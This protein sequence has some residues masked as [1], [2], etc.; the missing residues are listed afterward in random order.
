MRIGVFILHYEKQDVTDRC[1]DAVLADAAGVPN[2]HVFVIDNGSPT[3][4]VRPNFTFASDVPL[5]L[6]RFEQNEYLIKAFNRAM[7]EYPCGIYVCMANDTKPRQGMLAKLAAALADP[8]VGVVAPGTNDRGAGIL[9][10]PYPANDWETV[11]TRH[12]DNTC[13]AFRYDVAERVGFPSCEGHVHRACWASNQEFCYRVRQAGYK[14]LAVRAAYIWH[15][16]DG[17]QDT[18]AFSAG[19]EWLMRMYGAAK[20]AEIWA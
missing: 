20:A 9:N 6:L 15:A 7:G 5:T 13:W 17:G 1:L 3:P 19:R 10:V 11:E 12:V 2:A 14:V 8:K 4:Y 16:H 18:E